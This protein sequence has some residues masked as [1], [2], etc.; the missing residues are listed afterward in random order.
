MGQRELCQQEH[1]I[2]ARIMALLNT[3]WMEIG[4]VDAIWVDHSG[5]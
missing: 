1:G 5:E 4:L 3:T 2:K